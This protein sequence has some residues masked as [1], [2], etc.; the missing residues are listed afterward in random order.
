MHERNKKRAA[1]FKRR[2]T[3]QIARRQFLQTSGLTMA[4]TYFGLGHRSSAPVRAK[5]EAIRVISQQPQYYHGW[6]TL[7]R[8]RDGQLLLVCSGGR[9]AHVCPFGRVELMRSNDDGE[10]WSWPQVLLDGPID[11]RDTGVLETTAGSILV[12]TFTSL[13]YEPVLDQA[14]ARSSDGAQAWPK[15]KLA[16]WNAARDR[17]SPE[18]RQKE[19]GVWMIRSTDG[20]VTWS[21]RYNCQVNS[22]HGPVQLS[23]G[24]LVYTGKDLWGGTSR[25]GVCESTDDGL[26]WRW[27]TEIAPRK[28]DDRTNYHELHAVETADGRIVVH[29]RNHN[30]AN[31]GETL[32]SESADGGKTWS[33]PRSIGV[34][35]LPSHLLR[36]RDGGL[37]M[38]YGYRRPPFGNQARLSRDHGRTWSDPI[39]ISDDGVS[40]DLGYPST[41]QLGDG[42]FVTVWYELQKGSAV[43][44]LRQAHWSLG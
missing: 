7:T 20:G 24:R 2:V 22:P 33:V 32:Q 34:W 13:A 11:D 30:T 12:T 19:L 14:N 43:A 15:E 28:G 17:I 31:A 9:E 6:P 27:L 35:G 25:V 21:A 8:R 38:S 41:V 1:P 10:T 16:R 40:G 42:S 36:I 23:D 4:G 18:A 5:V 3:E 44:V 26:T 39:I 37:V 29:I